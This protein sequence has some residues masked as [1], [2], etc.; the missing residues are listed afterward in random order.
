MVVYFDF[1]LCRRP[2]W[3][4]SGRSNAENDSTKRFSKKLDLPCLESGYYSPRH[5]EQISREMM[6]IG[7]SQ[8]C[9]QFGSPIWRSMISSGSACTMQL[10]WYVGI[11][12]LCQAMETQAPVPIARAPSVGWSVSDIVG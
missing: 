7:V 6:H 3:H 5:L 1:L 8:F 9:Y 12:F 11:G 2:A 4:A 10:C